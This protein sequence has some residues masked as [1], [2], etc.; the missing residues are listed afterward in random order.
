[1]AAYFAVEKAV[2]DQDCAVWRINREWAI[3]FSI[4][5][6]KSAHKTKAPALGKPYDEGEDEVFNQT[7]FQEK[8]V[9]CACPQTPF[10]LNERLRIQMGV[11]MVPGSIEASFEENL[12]ALPQHEKDT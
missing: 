8:P 4:N 1:M 2:K 6:L 7:L 9:L 3:K 11:F 12:R 10:R 5:R